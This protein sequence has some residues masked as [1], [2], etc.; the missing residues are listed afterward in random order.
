MPNLLTCLQELDCEGSEAGSA[1]DDT[2]YLSHN[3]TV[4]GLQ[5]LGV[6]WYRTPKAA[7]GTTKTFS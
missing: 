3:G 7:R 6:W 2:Q 5:T 1:G 4:L